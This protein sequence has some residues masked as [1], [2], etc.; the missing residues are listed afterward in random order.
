MFVR[1]RPQRLAWT[2]GL[3]LL[4]VLAGPTAAQEREAAKEADREQEVVVSGELASPTRTKEPSVAAYRLDR[5]SL[6]APGRPLGDALREVPGMQVTQLGGFGAPTTFR[7][8]GASAAQTPVYFGAVKLNDEVGGVADLGLVPPE[9]VESVEVYRSNA[10]RTAA[11]L[12]IGGAVYLVPRRSPPNAALVRGELGSFGTRALSVSTGYS[13]KERSSSVFVNVDGAENDYSFHDSRGTLYE[14]DDDRET[15]LENADSH[16][17]GA[18][19]QH[20]ER[21]GAAELEFFLGHAS[22]EQGALKLALVPTREARVTYDRTQAQLTSTIRGDGAKLQLSSALVSSETSVRDPLLELSP[23]STELETPGERFEQAALVEH[24]LGRHFT[25]TERLSASVERFRRYELE[26]RE[27]VERLSAQRFAAR[28]A[29][30]VDYRP[31]E[32]LTVNALA[33][34]RCVSTTPLEACREALPGGRGGATLTLG[35]VE[36]FASIARAVRVPTLSELHGFNPFVRGNPSLVPEEAWTGEIGTRAAFGARNKAPLVW[37]DLSGFLRHSDNLVVF[38]RTAQ[39]YVTAQNRAESRTLGGELALGVNP[40]PFAFTTQVSLLD[41]RDTSPE[42]TTRNDVLPFL[43][44]ATASLSAR[45]RVLETPESPLS[46]GLGA[47]GFVQ[48]SRFADAA[49]LAVI[50]AQGNVDLETDVGLQGEVLTL[51]ATL[52]NLFDTPR[53]DLVGFPLPGRS[54]FVSLESKFR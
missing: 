25:F 23:F 51:R 29:G 34:L 50:P 44:A 49:G 18:W 1:F 43:S 12:G 6:E 31:F 20:R 48:S 32:A 11:E 52:R 13:T 14:P 8:R 47:R 36:S 9:F 24:E 16:G 28:L 4:S 5:E 30:G 53:Y 37:V 19:F 33:E 27:Q 10:P 39:G 42:R 15:T 40:G 3:P 41:P 54:F 2:R 7:L 26:G 22:R 17:F 35:P 45:V 38:V 21:I 46:W